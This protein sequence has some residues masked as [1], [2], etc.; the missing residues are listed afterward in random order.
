MRID[1][2]LKVAQITKRRTISNNLAKANRVEVN[3]RIVKPSY[4]VVVG[5]VITLRFGNRDLIVKVL[6]ENPKQGKNQ[7]IAYTVIDSIRRETITN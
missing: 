6:N 5:D 2:Y 4:E 3:G 7:D 1:K